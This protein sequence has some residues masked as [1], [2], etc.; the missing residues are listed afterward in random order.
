MNW[1]LNWVRAVVSRMRPK[2]NTTTSAAPKSSI[3]QGWTIIQYKQRVGDSDD[4][5]DVHS[6]L[7]INDVDP[8]HLG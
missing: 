3:V 8:G 7:S 1:Y 4:D 6:D 5:D 2:L